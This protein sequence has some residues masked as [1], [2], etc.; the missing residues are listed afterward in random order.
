MLWTY[1]CVH[2]IASL[3]KTIQLSKVCCFWLSYVKQHTFSKVHCFGFGSPNPLIYR[4]KLFGCLVPV[5]M[6]DF[7]GTNVVYFEAYLGT[8]C[9]LKIIKKEHLRRSNHLFIHKIY[10]HSLTTQF[11]HVHPEHIRSYMNTYRRPTLTRAKPITCHWKATRH[12]FGKFIWKI[13]YKN[14]GP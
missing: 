1:R 5:V 7:C 3:V 10:H 12:F 11:K 4:C 14:L 8:F 9:L 2:K 6:F 13:L